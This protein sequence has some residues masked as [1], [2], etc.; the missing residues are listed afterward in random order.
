[1]TKLD[2]LM[3][4]GRW[5]EAIRHVRT[6]VVLKDTRNRAALRKAISLVA[7]RAYQIGILHT[8]PRRIRAVDGAKAA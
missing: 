3:L 6:Y 5:L 2:Q 4:E 7:L 1:M 8:A